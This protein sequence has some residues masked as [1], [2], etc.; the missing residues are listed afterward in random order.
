MKHVPVIVAKPMDH[1]DYSRRIRTVLYDDQRFSDGELDLMH[2]PTLQRLYDLHQLGLTDRVFVDASHT[3]FSHVIGTIQQTDGLL[4]AIESNLNK[5]ADAAISYTKIDGGKE[6]RD[7]R[8]FAMQIQQHWPAVRLMALLHDLTHAPYGHTLE[9]EIELVE[10]RH[11]HPTRQAEAFFHLLVEWLAWQWRELGTTDT[12][13]LGVDHD[14]TTRTLDGFLATGEYVDC[15]SNAEELN[16]VMDAARRA[17]VTLCSE[18]RPA[19]SIAAISPSQLRTYLKHLQFA[20]RGLFH[21]ELAHSREAPP[22]ILPDTQ[23]RVD[24]LIEAILNDSRISDPVS[25]EDR[26]C[27]TRDAYLLDVIGNTICADLLDYARRDALSSGLHLNYDSDRIVENFTLVG[28]EPDF[29]DIAKG[30]PLKGKEMV[31]AA[32]ALFSHKFRP[33]IV[34]ELVSVLNARYFVNERMLFHPTKCVAGATLGAA[35]QWMGWRT[36]PPHFQRRGDAVFLNEVREAALL[37]RDRL[38][39]ASADTPFTRQV[40]ERLIKTFHQLPVVGNI[41]AAE[42]LLRDLVP[43]LEGIKKRLTFRQYL[44]RWTTTALVRTFSEHCGMYF[45]DSVD[46]DSENTCENRRAALQSTLS[47]YFPDSG[48]AVVE[49]I[50]EELPTVGKLIERLD[51]GLYLLQRLA[52]RRY[53]RRV[54]NLLS[55]KIGDKHT[56]TPTAIADKFKNPMVRQIAE[57]EIERELH[58]NKG[59]IVI[60]CPSATGPRKIANVLVTYGDFS[61]GRESDTKRLVE[62]DKLSGPPVGIFE[63][64]A[65]LITAI[66]G[67][68]SS[69]WR[70]S[71]S[72][73][74]PH[75][76]NALTEA[77]ETA[78]GSILHQV[79]TEGGKNAP[80]GNDPSMRRE[81]EVMIARENSAIDG[82]IHEFIAPGEDQERYAQAFKVFL[83]V[84]LPHP[85]FGPL[86]RHLQSAARSQDVSESSTAVQLE[87][88]LRTA[89]THVLAEDQLKME[90]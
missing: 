2:T 1:I 4:R 84:G 72:V 88:A 63:H 29:A 7:R 51:A 19:S 45:A 50:E 13:A 14:A 36:L 76:A 77:F 27:I 52:A 82:K 20:F 28:Y 86:I 3:R 85:T 67:M 43:T 37:T 58:I 39:A 25:S 17:G 48:D 34:G 89:L 87:K 38:T 40:A 81:L 9:D 54:F 10:E 56:Y 80:L 70:L 74:R 18:E 79:V 68:Y 46:S 41:V 24:Q 22:E 6:L 16:E 5:H 64:H 11:D 69:T 57:R 59:G 35:L 78:I 65:A 30:H 23:Y 8:Y 21:L 31:R 60:H 62:I 61:S 73:V 66:Q 55:G 15:R 32:V 90:Y 83:K 49:L 42:A 53:P 71:V 12:S 75:D 33:E 47:D 26:F 44:E